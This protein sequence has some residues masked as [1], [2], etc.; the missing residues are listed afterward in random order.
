[1]LCRIVDH[2]GVDKCQLG[3]TEAVSLHLFQLVLNL[4]LLDG[5]TEPPPTH[6]WPGV[7]RGMLETCLQ[8]GDCALRPDHPGWEQA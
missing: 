6:H 1:V 8:F 3:A 5:D 4:G 2:L 7:V